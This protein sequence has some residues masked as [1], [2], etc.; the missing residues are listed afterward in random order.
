MSLYPP[1]E[2][3]QLEL[4]TRMPERFRRSDTHCQWGHA[5]RPG[6]ALPCFIEGPAFDRDGHLWITD[7]PYGRLFRVAPDG[8][9]QL[10]LEYDGWPNGLAIHEDGR[11]FIADYK[12]G[13]LVHE[14]GSGRVQ[15]VVADRYSEHFRGCNDL[16]FD[17][18]G[19]LYFTDQGQSGLHM[20]NGRVYRYD[21]VSKRLDCL[22]DT[23]PSPNGLVLTAD[24]RTLLVA[25]TRGNC[26]WR[27]PLMPDGGV[28]KVGLFIQLSG[29]LGGPDGMAIGADDSLLV[30]H[31]G[32]G[33]AWLFDRLGAPWLRLRTDTG[34]A[35]TNAAFGGIDRREIFVTESVSGSILRARL[36]VAGAGLYSGA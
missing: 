33:C 9:W 21:P 30:A 24:E 19:R 14:P 6:E 36:P 28:S 35:V 15:R 5:N 25:M 1:P 13:I 18:A 7:I 20:P 22:I 12:R 27:L 23:A 4:W 17:S 8:D 3:L 16:I 34:L 29:G 32:N 31:V 10:A 26:V 2:D 11:V